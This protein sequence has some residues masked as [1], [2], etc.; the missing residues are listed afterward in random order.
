MDGT[1][2][3]GGRWRPV[4]AAVASEPGA[5]PADG[6]RWILP[7]GM[8]VARR[9]LCMLAQPCLRQAQRASRFRFLEATLLLVGSGTLILDDGGMQMCLEGPAALMAVAQNV[10]ADLQ[11]IPGGPDAQFR[12]LLLAFSPDVIREFHVRHEHDSASLPPVARCSGVPLDEDLLETIHHCV[13]GVDASRV[14]DRVL[15][16]R[17]VGLLLA[18]ADRGIVF[19]RPARQSV[20]DHLRM[21]LCDTPGH[22]WTTA[23]AGRALAMSEA[24]LRRRLAAEQLRFES[25]L[26]EVRMHHAMALLQTTDW[27]IASVAQACGY[28]AHG[29]FTLRFRER[30]GCSPSQ[31][32]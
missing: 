11:K 20:G 24:T 26:L 1:G 4:S 3:A 5:T 22:P 21:L 27:N 31:V 13:H 23:Q 19:A 32:R 18:L 25:L 17:L 28:Q 15:K 30:F 12:S 7:S 8:P 14:S 6:Q 9:G 16:H 2:A 10:C 29:R